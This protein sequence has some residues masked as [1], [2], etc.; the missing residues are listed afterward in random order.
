ML[1]DL[2]L[3]IKEKGY[4]NKDIEMACG[5]V[6]DIFDGIHASLVGNRSTVKINMA[7][8]A[9]MVSALPRTKE[10]TK[11]YIVGMTPNDIKNLLDKIK[12][13]IG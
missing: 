7:W 13:R 11:E 6:D 8:K 3:P 1:K 5:I 10:G 4:C 9:F 12:R 2:K